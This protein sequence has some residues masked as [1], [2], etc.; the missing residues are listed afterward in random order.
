MEPKKRLIPF[1]AAL[2]LLCG[3]A[4]QP[5]AVINAPVIE[6]NQ[7]I[8]PDLSS[9]PSNEDIS[10]E[11][12]SPLAPEKTDSG[13]KDP[14][15]PT[16]TDKTPPKVPESTTGGDK[17]TGNGSS[18]GSMTD[19]SN[20][21]P[22]G[23][24]SS[25]GNA[26][27]GSIE[28]TGS[29]GDSASSG[30][31]GSTGDSTSSGNAGST[32]GSTS[33]GNA[34]STGGSTSSG[35]AGS[36]GSSDTT[37]T[38]STPETT[39]PTDKPPSS[40]GS[41]ATE[42]PAETPTPTETLFVRS[43]GQVVTSD[44]YDIICRVVQNEVGGSFE[45]EAI[46][47]MA[48]ASYSYIKYY[49]SYLNTAPTLALS[50]NTISTKVANV[51]KEVLGQAVY[52]NGRYANCTYFALSAGCTTSAQSVWGT[53]QY[54]YLVSVDSSVDTAYSSSWS[55]YRTTKIF[56][57]AELAQR[58]NAA[59]G[60]SL[61]AS[62]A[63]ADP[64]SW[65]EILS[66]TD[67]QYVGS[68]RVGTATTTGRNIRDNILGLRSHAFDVSYDAASGSFTFTVYGYGHGVG[69]SQIGANYYAQQGWDYKQ[70]LTHYYTGTSVS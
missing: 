14:S 16:T 15:P 56:T 11:E 6:S 65:I 70:I 37:T 20:Q 10:L 40:G 8:L 51:V 17:T 55:S 32:G 59:L 33:S 61:D 9:I 36:S 35:N 3:C 41:T 31:A 34:G 49:N 43:G 63:D 24:G 66:R 52:Y 64:G 39:P 68:V 53:T 48:V 46:K 45:T 50:S 54:P 38:P 69:M 57:A 23:D 13:T 44:A 30:N 67:G 4:G 18:S 22:A 25:S 42:P 58:M 29:T 27:S 60:T 21:Q 47:A 1:L 5:V 28:N 19:G 12:D 26:A 7:V 2:L 62:A